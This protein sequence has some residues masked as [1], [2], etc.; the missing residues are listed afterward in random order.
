MSLDAALVAF[1]ALGLVIFLAGG[2]WRLV[3]RRTRHRSGP[4]PDVPDASPTAVPI[5]A[6]GMNLP[7][8]SLDPTAP[9]KRLA[10]G[11]RVDGMPEGQ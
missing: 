11:T 8:S 3:R 10:N 5:A 4:L 7:Y 9:P 2:V 1:L 6:P